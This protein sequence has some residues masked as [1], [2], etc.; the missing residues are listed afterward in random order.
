MEINGYVMEGDFSSE[1]AGCS[2]WGFCRKYEHSFFIKRFTEVTYPIS[3]K[4][5]ASILEKIMSEFNESLYFR[6]LNRYPTLSQ[7]E[8]EALLTIIRTS[9]ASQLLPQATTTVSVRTKL[10]PQ[11]SLSSSAT[12]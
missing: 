10:L 5:S 7:Q 8:E 11:L 3:D 1:N 4:I 9:S 2:L 12:S 6:D